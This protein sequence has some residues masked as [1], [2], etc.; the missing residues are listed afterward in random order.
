MLFKNEIRYGFCSRYPAYL[1]K[2][3]QQYNHVT[4]TFP[5]HE[6]RWSNAPAFLH[7]QKRLK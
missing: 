2:Q 1:V 5:M 6:L 7:K 3:H 4:V